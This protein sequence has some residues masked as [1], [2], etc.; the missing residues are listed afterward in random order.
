[1]ANL[2]PEDFARLVTFFVPEQV[3]AL[4]FSPDGKLLAVAAADKVHIYRI[5][6]QASTGSTPSNSGSTS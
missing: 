2:T 5:P 1:M 3:T 4:A 6:P